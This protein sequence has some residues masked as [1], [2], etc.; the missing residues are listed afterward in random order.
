MLA[1]AP[2]YTNSPDSFDLRYG[3]NAQIT[4]LLPSTPFRQ[5][6]DQYANLTTIQRQLYNWHV[7]LGHMNFATIQ[8]MTCKNMGI[9]RALM[10]CQPPLCQACQYG[11]AKWGSIK[12]PHPIGEWPL[13]PGEMCCVNQ[14]ITGCA[15][16]PYTMQGWCSQC[17]YTICTFF[18]NVAHVTFS[19]ISG[20]QLML[21]RPLLESNAMSNTASITTKQYKNIVLTMAYLLIGSLQRILPKRASVILSLAPAPTIWMVLWN[22][23]SGSSPHGH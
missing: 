11:K 16:L 12:D 6:A 14:M 17:C 10:L 15:G 13:L 5:T 1:N 20:K 23:A 18:V 4:P 19:H 22:I 9:T 7:C 2:S 8:S 3:F 21:W